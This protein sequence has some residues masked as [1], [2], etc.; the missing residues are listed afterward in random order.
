MKN[1]T[2]LVCHQ[3]FFIKKTVVPCY[4]SNYK[5]KGELDWYFNILSRNKI[6]YQK[7]DIPI[8]YYQRGGVGEQKYMLNFREMIHVIK[9]HG[10]FIGL[11]ASSKQIMKYAVKI[12]LIVTKRYK[13]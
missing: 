12:F 5:L 3:A 13:F 4:N 10:G 6:Y 9:K 11:L 2:S 7:R 8:V 1:L